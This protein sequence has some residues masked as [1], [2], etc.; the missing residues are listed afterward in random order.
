MMPLAATPNITYLMADS[1]CT[2][3]AVALAAHGN[4]Q[5][6]REGRKLEGDDERENLD[7]ADQHGK[8]EHAERQEKIVLRF[9]FLADVGQFA[10]EEK[11]EEITALMTILSHCEK[12]STRYAP[13]KRTGALPRLNDA[14]TECDEGDEER[15]GAGA[16]CLATHRG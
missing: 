13:S 15:A 6:E 12:A 4:H 9:G 16:L 11:H 1:I 5:V 3:L 10:A 14:G 2:P 7:A 8:A